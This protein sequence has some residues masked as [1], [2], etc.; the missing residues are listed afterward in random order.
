MVSKLRMIE[1]VD[2]GFI[3]ALRGDF[4]CTVLLAD[5]GRTWDCTYTTEG[6]D[7]GVAQIVGGSF[8]VAIQAGDSAEDVAKTFAVLGDRL[9]QWADTTL[10]KGGK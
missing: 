9:A 2:T 4:I 1:L 10:T 7:E 6:C 5:K 3:K 8:A